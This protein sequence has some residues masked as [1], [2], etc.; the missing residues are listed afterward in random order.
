MC[1]CVDQR[2]LMLHAYSSHTCQFF[3]DLSK[4][5]RFS[6]GTKQ[7]KLADK[8]SL[9][10]SS[11]ILWEFAHYVGNNSLI[12]SE[13]IFKCDVNRNFPDVT[14]VAYTG[15]EALRANHT[16]HGKASFQLPDIRVP[17]TTISWSEISNKNG[18]IRSFT[19]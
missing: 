15:T 16:L 10:T 5:E 8:F 13:S 6:C 17:V 3:V 1:V 11:V 14:I 4:N 19:F 12:F 9:H 2:A 7:P 18:F